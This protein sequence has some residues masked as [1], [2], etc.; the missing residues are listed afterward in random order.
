MRHRLLSCSL[1]L[2]PLAA[3]A[4]VSA[5][6]G[7]YED[8]AVFTDAGQD[9]TVAT[10]SE[11]PVIG[12]NDAKIDEPVDAYIEPRCG[13]ERRE[14]TETCDDGNTV[15]GDGCDAECHTETGWICAIVGAACAP[16]KCGDG[17]KI[18]DEECDDGNTVATDGCDATC[19]LQE[20]FQCLT[21]GMPC[22]P[23]VCGNGL[24]E[25][26]EQCDDGNKRAYDGCDATCKKEPTCVVGSGCAAVCGD[27]LKY[28]SEA[29]DD[30]NTRDGDGCSATC[31]LEAGFSCATQVQAMPA[32]IDLPII[33]RDFKRGDGSTNLANSGHPDFE[34]FGGGVVTGEVQ[35]TLDGDAKP[36]YKA[37]ATQL[38]SATMFAKWYRDDALNKVELG[39]LRVKKQADDSYVFDS[40]T[41]NP[42]GS[43]NPGG[44]FFPLTGK[45]WSSSSVPAAQR[46]A[47]IDRA[48][49]NYNF[50]F[51]SEVKFWFSYDAAAAAP[52]LEFTGDD[53]VWVF[54][55]GKL[56]LEIAGVHSVARKSVTI[57]KDCV[58]VTNTTNDV[59]KIAGSDLSL[60]DKGIYDIAVFQAE[61]HTID[62]NYKLTLRGFERAK[63]ECAPVCG[64]GIKTR[65]EACDEGANN[66][67]S[68]TPAYGKCAADC[69]SRGGYCGD[70]I[71]QGEAGE[72]CD[73][74]PG[75][76]ANCKSGTVQ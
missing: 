43:A 1:V 30:G 31:T 38:T 19:K 60:Q 61:R 52:K 40:A 66:D 65:T 73:G 54:I 18:G 5:A 23:T 68:A 3:G 33:Y 14:G 7:T 76:N 8:G 16:A 22:T 62:S 55:N 17:L 44:Q 24:K 46:E 50:H 71:V 21:P 53:D 49:T 29:C 25:G 51:T 35:S 36:V 32:F 41:S 37:G 6:C 27:G 57:H 39:T 15:A 63:S 59:C 42:D 11:P 64:D 70:A 26:T 69:K 9:T 20:G 12:Q 74:T 56:A 28:P 72:S 58:G 47:L 4:F 45:G 67:T 75:C 13:N 48:G 34:T 2:M 10:D